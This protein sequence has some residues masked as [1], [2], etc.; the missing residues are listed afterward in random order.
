MAKIGYISILTGIL[1]FVG[2][3]MYQMMIEISMPL[4]LKFA[5]I[6]IV[7]GIIVVVI[8][9]FVEKKNEKKESEDY[10]KY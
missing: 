1:I 7:L 8:K 5:V 3:A 2:Y 10:K 9:Q 6:L 4:I